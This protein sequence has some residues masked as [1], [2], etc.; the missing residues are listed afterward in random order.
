MARST[1]LAGGTIEAAVVPED[2]PPVPRG[3]AA[4]HAAARD[5][6][7]L[8][9]VAVSVREER[10]RGPRTLVVGLV[11][12]SIKP[13]RAV[14]VS[15]GLARFVAGEVVE[16]L[17]HRPP[18]PLASAAARVGHRR[19]LHVDPRIAEISMVGTESEVRPAAGIVRRE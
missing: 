9:L 16:I 7:P 17:R 12:L 3:S 15:D 19:V 11:A 10:R 18:R 1:F 8:V 6:G 13:C 2:V 14:G 4:L 5:V